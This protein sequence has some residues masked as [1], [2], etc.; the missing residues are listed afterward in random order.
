MHKLRK[1]EQGFEVVRLPGEEAEQ[2]PA[3]VFRIVARE[4]GVR[5]QPFGFERGGWLAHGDWPSE[6]P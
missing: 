4:R 2:L 3:G 5:G 6:S 1:A